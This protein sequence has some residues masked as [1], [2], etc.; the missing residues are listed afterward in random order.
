[1]NI[2]ESIANGAAFSV[3]LCGGI[4]IIM[5]FHWPTRTKT[6]ELMEERNKTDE[7]IANALER[8]AKEVA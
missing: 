4:A 8:I 7:R 3:G 6:V 1:V 5:V 2:L